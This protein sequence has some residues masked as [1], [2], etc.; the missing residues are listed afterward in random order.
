MDQSIINLYIFNETRNAAVYGVGTYISELT[1]SLKGGNMNVSLVH[2]RSDKPKLTIENRDGI[3]YWDVPSPVGY[4]QWD[5]ERYFRNVV[6]LL[7][8]YIKNRDNL[9]FHLNYNQGKV[10]AQGLKAA[11]DCKVVAVVHYCSWALSLQGN[12]TR[13]RQIR[14]KPEKERNDFEK[15]IYFTD[16]YEIELYQSVD[17]IIV[18]SEYTFNL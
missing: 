5:H 7:R 8:I 16:D 14:N 15:T 9:V 3:T 12:L 17:R 10:L 2:L 13:F 1:H 18:L 4:S 6:Y 11:F